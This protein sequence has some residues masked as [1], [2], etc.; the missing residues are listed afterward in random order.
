V[1][2][3]PATVELEKGLLLVSAQVALA[4][5]IV[6]ATLIVS[7]VGI[8]LRRRAEAGGAQLPTMPYWLL[9]SLLSVGVLMLLALVG[10]LLVTAAL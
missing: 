9:I 6:V 7:L 1:E 5:V 8:V 3:R 4:L 2:G 10:V